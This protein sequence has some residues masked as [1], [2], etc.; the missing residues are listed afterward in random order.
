MI[1]IGRAKFNPWNNKLTGPRGNIELT[2][3]PGNLL[4]VM[5]KR[6]NRIHVSYQE[7]E[8]FTS[9]SNKALRVQIT[10]LRAALLSVGA[11]TGIRNIQTEG[12]CLWAAQ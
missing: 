10:K 7:L 4:R 11:D 9:G 5:G 6:G 2:R 8:Q 1:K 3:A 12:Y